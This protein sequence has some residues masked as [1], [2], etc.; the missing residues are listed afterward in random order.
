[1]LSCAEE[2]GYSV[3]ELWED[4]IRPYSKEQIPEMFCKDF[5]LMRELSQNL[6]D[7]LAPAQVRSENETIS[8]VI[9]KLNNHSQWDQLVR[10]GREKSAEEYGAY[11]CYALKDYLCYVK[12]PQIH[13]LLSAIAR[14]SDKN[15][16]L[17][18][19][20]EWFKQGESL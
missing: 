4:K 15:P 2:I 18:K 8:M 6:R 19:A 20:I 12:N 11:I 5:L 9:D 3:Y 7:K 13:S 10:Y 17:H 1:M 16:F 14:D